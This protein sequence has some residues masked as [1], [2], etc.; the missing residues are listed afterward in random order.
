VGAG[1][2]GAQR[3]WCS[4]A[5]RAR[6]G[7]DRVAGRARMGLPPAWQRDMTAHASMRH[8]PP[9]AARAMAAPAPA[10]PPPFSGT[11]LLLAALTHSSNPPSCAWSANTRLHDFPWW[12][13]KWGAAVW[14]SEDLVRVAAVSK[15]LHAAAKTADHLWD[16]LLERYKKQHA[17]NFGW[18]GPEFPPRLRGKCRD[19]HSHLPHP[20]DRTAR[21]HSP[22]LVLC[23]PFGRTKAR[24]DEA[25]GEVRDLFIPASEDA[26]SWAFKDPEPS[27]PGKQSPGVWLPRPPALLRC[28][29][30]GGLSFECGRAF[31]EHCSSWAHVQMMQ[32][33]EER[34]P[35]ELWDPR[36]DPHAFAAL[37]LPGC[38]SALRL[39][40]DTVMEAYNAPVDEA[41]MSNM[42]EHADWIKRSVEQYN[43]NAWEGTPHIPA[44]ELAEAAARWERS[45]RSH[46]RKSVVDS[47]RGGRF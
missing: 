4:H 18:R 17:F 39:H 12:C 45:D 2:R 36:S 10:A 22:A 20:R 9:P 35:E 13:K 3:T 26:K 42:Q 29:P 34:L 37:S 11:D 44:E 1:W 15:E 31:K 32:D 6:A 16:P 40:V 46:G 14:E 19:E 24:F 27:S 38:Y 28:E 43:E 41:G 30:C 5:A 33:P 7:H 23:T 47:D 25:S 21:A 8:A